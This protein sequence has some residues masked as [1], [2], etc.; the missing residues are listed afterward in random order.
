[1]TTETMANI[2]LLLNAVNIFMLT[3]LV[4]LRLKESRH[5]N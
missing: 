3:V 4:A 2:A 5:D 1:M